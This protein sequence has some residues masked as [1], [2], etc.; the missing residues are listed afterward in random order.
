MPG[1]RGNTRIAEVIGVIE[2]PLLEGESVSPSI[3]VEHGVDAN[4]ILR[5]ME[6]IDTATGMD[7]IVAGTAVGE[8]IPTGI[9][10][11]VAVVAMDNVV[12]VAADQFVRALV[13]VER[14][15]AETTSNTVFS[16]TAQNGVI[17]L[18]AV[19]RVGSGSTVEVVGS[20][21]T[22]DPAIPRPTVEILDGI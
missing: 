6:R 1:L 8:I 17:A 4:I 14:V 11:V 19:D 10:H 7:R 5:T 9:D 21:A 3:G 16:A 20:V 12:P 2:C 15:V 22:G 13:A 18:A